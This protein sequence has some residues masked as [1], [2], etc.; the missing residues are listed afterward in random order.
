MQKGAF[1]QRRQ[2]R[3]G[4]RQ[5]QEKQ[6]RSD[7]APQEIPHGLLSNSNQL[8]LPSLDERSAAFEAHSVFHGEA[9]FSHERRGVQGDDGDW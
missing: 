2:R 5:E 1:D 4:E 7:N 3:R 9:R 6:R 8:I